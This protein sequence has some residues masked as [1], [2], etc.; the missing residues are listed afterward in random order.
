MGR[1][2]AVLAEPEAGCLGMAAAAHAAVHGGSATER[3]AAWARTTDL[4]EPDPRRTAAHTEGF[5]RYRALYAAMRGL[6][7]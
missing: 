6:G 1:P 3:A 7:S 4:I 2:L 5:S